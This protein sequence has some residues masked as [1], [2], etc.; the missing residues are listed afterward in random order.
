MSSGSTNR[1]AFLYDITSHI[2]HG[3]DTAGGLHSIY[4]ELRNFTFIET[5][6]AL[7]SN[8]FQNTCKISLFNQIAHFRGFPT[9]QE[10]FGC[11]RPKP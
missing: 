1:L 9:G 10:N 11:R 7:G 6:T 5:I 2:F 8:F 3:P 4:H